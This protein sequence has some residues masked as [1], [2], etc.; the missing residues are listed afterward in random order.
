MADETRDDTT[1]SNDADGQDAE[2]ED[3]GVPAGTVELLAY[4]DAQYGDRFDAERRE[5]LRDRVASLRVAGETLSEA[6]LENG[7]EP[8]TTF[9]AYRGDE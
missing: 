4:L 7:D 5:R 3:G 8:A 6:D 1:T 2:A 9:A